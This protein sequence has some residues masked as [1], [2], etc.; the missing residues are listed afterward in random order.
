[1]VGPS[2]WHDH[3]LEL[4]SSH[5]E[6]YICLRSMRDNC[7]VF[8]QSVL[9]K[10]SAYFMHPFT[11]PSFHSSIHTNIHQSINPSFYNICNNNNN[12]NN[13]NNKRLRTLLLDAT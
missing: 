7:S 9:H 1:M 11:Y 4:C 10:Y 12:N 13:N 2:T 3:P 6:H 8:L 5:H